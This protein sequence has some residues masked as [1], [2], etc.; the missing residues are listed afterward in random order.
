MN[1]FGLAVGEFL[2]EEGSFS[3]ISLRIK[4][5]LDFKFQSVMMTIQS[6]ERLRE[7]PP[8]GGVSSFM[9]KT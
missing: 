1:R 9:E 5:L 8:T 6:A 7:T 3:I 2:L 4:I